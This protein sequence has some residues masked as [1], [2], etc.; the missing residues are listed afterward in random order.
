MTYIRE[1]WTLWHTL[2]KNWVLWHTSENSEL[3]DIHW[4]KL[5]GVTYIGENW[6]VWHTLEN[7]GLCDIQW[8]NLGCVTYHT[9]EK[10]GLCDILGVMRVVTS[11]WGL[12]RPSSIYFGLGIVRDVVPPII[13]KIIFAIWK[14]NMRQR[15]A[16]RA[17][18]ASLCLLWFLNVVATIIRY[19]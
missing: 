7:F 13:L 15:L 2:E 6:V 14:R 1:F 12:T 10:T 11:Q 17:E 18:S 19:D 3:C 5:G 8:G 9:L 16:F 4:R